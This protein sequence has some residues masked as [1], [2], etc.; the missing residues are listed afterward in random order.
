MLYGTPS[1]SLSWNHGLYVA[2]FGGWLKAPVLLLSIWFFL[3][4]LSTLPGA[5]PFLR[6]RAEEAAPVALA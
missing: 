6:G 5:F 1:L 2:Y 4:M 3:P